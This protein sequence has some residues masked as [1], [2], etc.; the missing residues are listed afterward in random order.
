MPIF[1]YKAKDKSGKILEGNIEANDRQ[2]V[3]DKLDKTGYFPITVEEEGK[4]ENFLPLGKVRLKEI[5]TFIRQ[6]SDLLEGGLAL[7]K[8][9][10]LLY[11]QS[12]SPKLKMIIS[13]INKDVQNGINFSDSLNKYPKIFPKTLVSMVRAGEIGGVLAKA[14]DKVG[15]YLEKVEDL[16]MKVKTALTYPCF[17]FGVGVVSIFFIM[18]FII[19]KLVIMF[20][21]LGQNLPLPTLILI[22][23]SNFISKYWWLILACLI[24]TGIGVKRMISLQRGKLFLHKALLSLPLF[25]EII[26]KIDI[27]RFTQTLGTLLNNGVPILE[28]LGVINSS[29]GNLIIKGELDRI[30]KE[31]NE[32]KSVAESLSGKASFSPLMVSML[33]IAEKGGFLEKALLKLAANYEKEIDNSVK[34]ITS[35]LEPIVILGMGFIVGFIVIAML[36]PVFKMNILVE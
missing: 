4:S 16:Q 2:V 12:Q 15:D 18:T 28:A 31:V 25:G 19:P 10:S 33:G 1:T 9:L 6:L 32:G 3:I 36:L 14:L 17:L 30:Y 35:L 22:W 24:I 27:L 8:A 7:N 34:V 13:E 23:S 20:E 29:S 26:N 5:T 11:L 21:D